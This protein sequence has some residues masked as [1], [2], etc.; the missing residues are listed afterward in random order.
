MLIIPDYSKIDESLKLAREYAL[1]FEYNDFY[2]NLDDTAAIEE[3]ISFYRRNLPP[4]GCT[5]HG[6]F[7]DVAIGSID[8]QIRAVSR[9]RI[10]QSVEISK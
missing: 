2:L 8:A 7:Y 4:C 6:A 10:E 5:L 9:Q 3:K 1:G